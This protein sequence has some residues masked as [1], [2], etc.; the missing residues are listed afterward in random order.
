V[1]ARS[2]EDPD[3]AGYVQAVETQQVK[4]RLPQ[5]LDEIRKGLRTAGVVIIINFPP[6]HHH[7]NRPGG[8]HHHNI[9]FH[10]V[11]SPS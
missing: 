6:G 8:H 2:H 7:N 9:R 10:G 4:V 5:D 11:E 3:V 1:E